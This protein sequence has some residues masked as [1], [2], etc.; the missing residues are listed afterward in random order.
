[1]FGEGLARIC[2]DGWESGSDVANLAHVGVFSL[3][4]V[5]AELVCVQ[6]DAERVANALSFITV[7]V[8]GMF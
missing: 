7:I 4:A 2:R 1:M 5:S 6:M 8:L 3:Q